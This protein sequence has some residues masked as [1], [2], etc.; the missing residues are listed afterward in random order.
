MKKKLLLSLALLASVTLASA[1]RINLQTRNLVKNSNKTSKVVDG[2]KSFKTMPGNKMWS[3]AANMQGTKVS[4]APNK[5]RSPFKAEINNNVWFS[6][7]QTSSCYALGFD[8]LAKGMPTYFS[9]MEGQ[10]LYNVYSYIPK[11]YMKAVVDSVDILFYDGDKIQDSIYIYFQ[12][13]NDETGSTF[14]YYSYP[15]SMIK[16]V[17]SDGYLQSTYFVLPEAYT[18]PEGGCRVGYSFTAAEGARPIISY[19]TYDDYGVIEDSYYFTF[20]YTDGNRYYEDF[21]SD[22]FGCLTTAV[23]MDVTNCPKAN[24]SIGTIGEQTTLAGQSTEIYAYV[25]ND[26]LDSISSISYIKT[27]DG[28]AQPEATYTF[29]EALQAGSYEQ[30]VFGSETF[31]EGN[32]TVSVEI[33][34]VDGEE[35]LSDDKVADDGYFIALEKAATRNNVIEEFTSTS[36]G[37]CP[38]GAVALDSLSKLGYITLANH[39]DYSYTDPMTV[40]DNEEFIQSFASSFPSA[41]FN[42]YYVSDPYFAIGDASYGF[43]APYVVQVLDAAYPA[44]ATVNLTADWADNDGTQIKVNTAYTF[45]YDRDDA[46]YAIA[47]ILSED[48]MVGND[49]TWMQY[50]YFSYNAQYISYFSQ[51]P[52]LSAWTSATRYVTTSYDHVVVGVWGS[53]N[54][55]ANSVDPLISKGYENTDTRT[56]D[57]S[58]NTLIQN[59]SKLKLTALLLNNNNYTIANASQVTLSAPAGINGVKANSNSDLTEVA[60]YN[61]NGQRIAAPQKGL[62][63]VKMANGKSVKVL[64]K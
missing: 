64:V 40:A 32:H 43:S 22:G 28:T 20:N 59:K 5:F 12:A 54:G 39:I 50:N 38:K 37:W 33:T 62:N 19:D 58:S 53:L 56:L 24:V 4:L 48:G 26:A 31:T 6:Y 34:K 10:T 61:A 15:A 1:Q 46:N 8:V 42:R 63:I 21:A 30:V 3:G 47:Y 60:R 14:T 51:F 11:N 13:L 17:S 2:M 18:I 44:E 52:G 55:M 29:D 35:N 45:D 7:P 23:R 57:I 9:F 27:V 16:G 36:C 41:A 49:S 25:T